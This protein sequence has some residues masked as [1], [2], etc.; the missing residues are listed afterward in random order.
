MASDWIK[1]RVHL[2]SDP[3][4]ILMAKFLAHEKAFMG[5]L[6]GQ[7]P[8]DESD[9]E[10]VTSNVTRNVTRALCVTGLLQVWGA[11][12]EQGRRENDDLVISPCDLLVLDEISDVPCF[13]AAMCEVGWAVISDKCRN[14]I[15][16][17]NFFADKESP[18][19]RHKTANAERQARFRNRKKTGVT[20]NV[21]VTQK[22][23]ESRAAEEQSLLDDKA[24]EAAARKGAEL[25]AA[26]G[27]VGFAENVALLARNNSSLL[28][29]AGFDA[30]TA[31][32]Y[33]DVLSEDDI[34]FAIE[35]I[36]KR[37]RA[38]PLRN[39]T[40]YLRTLL[41]KILNGDLSKVGNGAPRG[42]DGE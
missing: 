28:M 41:D 37:G 18:E 14:S 40:G 4:V 42:P 16:L 38:K 11:A 31:R 7:A 25:P 1:M 22:V 13:G 35:T 27:S 24:A 12:R 3:K 5:W 21:T 2:K 39:P 17:P 34:R 33:A 23:T 26:N 20:S 10:H 29:R 15:V 32:R 36:A 6:T 19:E 9:Y 8:C 30:A